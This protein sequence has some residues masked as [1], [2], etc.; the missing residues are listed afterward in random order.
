MPLRFHY[1]NKLRNFLSNLLLNIILAIVIF[2]CAELGHLLGIRNTPLAISVVWP[3][4]GFSLAGL[5]L[6]GSAAW[7]GIFLGNFAY[8]L[9]E[10][11]LTSMTPASFFAATSIS[12]GSLLQA[13]TGN[14]IIRRYCTA[15][16]LN[17]VK[18]VFIFLL[19]AGLCTCLIASSIGTLTLYLY[20]PMAWFSAFETWLTFWVGDTMGVYIFTPLILVWTLQK[21]NQ[22]MKKYIIEALFMLTAF[23]II[24]LSAL[25][26][27]F[28][29]IHFY[30]PLCIWITYRF[31]MHGATLAV[32]FISSAV[33]IPPSISY[34]GFTQPNFEQSLLLLVSFLEVIVAT[35]LVIAA[36]LNER[37]AAWDLIRN[38]NVNLQQAVELH[39]EELKEKDTE[40]FMH[41]K[42]AALG[43][44]TSGIARQMQIPLQR[45]HVFSKSSMETL[46]RLQKTCETLPSSLTSKLNED[47]VILENY[48]SLISKFEIQANRISK[49]IEQQAILTTPSQ[50]KLMSVNVNFLLIK[51]LTEALKDVVR[52][53]PSFACNIRQELDKKVTMIAAVP[54]ELAHAFFHLIRN[55]IQGL[56]EKKDQF[57]TE[58]I[59][60]L[61]VRTTDKQDTIEIVIRDNGFGANEENITNFFSS[62]IETRS[63]TKTADFAEEGKE[64]TF[65]LAYDIITEVY[66][67]EIKVEGKEG[68]FLQFTIQL[69]KISSLL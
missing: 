40:I 62:F 24:I 26:L 23:F 45:L 13:L 41:E 7:P 27:N 25:A 52:N 65:A 20:F 9:L 34:V 46:N 36:V 50:L 39:R 64:L 68:E 51:C 69:P 61:T 6:F 3:A 35:S 15:S 67:G 49:T 44:L 12:I 4:T 8:N 31:G 63:A 1:E 14:F 38:H 29:L 66:H 37:E 5:L 16:Y 17:T 48:L 53:D 30:I 43:L 58:F 21:R 54:E 19:P 47:I 33:I 32:F 57:G 56:K 2:Y 18:D 11:Y 55:E 10:L 60:Q 42:I 59:P 22:N 28:P